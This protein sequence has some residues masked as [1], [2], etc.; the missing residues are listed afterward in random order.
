MAAREIL[1]I[2]LARLPRVTAAS[3][4]PAVAHI[5]PPPAAPT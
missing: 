5:A 1:K 3:V 2:G 4:G